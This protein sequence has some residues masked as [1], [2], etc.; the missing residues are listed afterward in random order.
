MMFYTIACFGYS[1]IMIYVFYRLPMRYK[2]VAFNRIGVKKMDVNN[3]VATKSMIK[4]DD[5]LDELI[6]YEHSSKQFDEDRK[7]S[8]KQSFDS[9]N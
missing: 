9:N 8:I 7:I 2:M 1:I 4:L 5:N 3:F 6:E